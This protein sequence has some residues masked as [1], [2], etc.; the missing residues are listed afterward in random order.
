MLL[1]QGKVLDAMCHG[2]I[3]TIPTMSAGKSNQGRTLCLS[4]DLTKSILALTFSNICFPGEL[5][6]LPN[7]TE[8]LKDLCQTL[9]TNQVLLRRNSIKL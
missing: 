4:T 8:H 5:W 1:L 2:F 7:M 6:T 9:V 3:L